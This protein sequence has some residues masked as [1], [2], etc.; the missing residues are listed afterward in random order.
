MGSFFLYGIAPSTYTFNYDVFGKVTKVLAGN[1]VLAI[2]T[3]LGNNGKLSKITY[4]NGF[5]EEYVYDTLENLSEIWYT[6]NSTRSLAYSY[7]YTSRGLIHKFEDHII[8]KAYTYKYDANDRLISYTEY[9]LDDPFMDF[10]DYNSR[11]S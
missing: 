4:A 7:E 2:Y 6:E 9:D 10:T 1:K 3:Y 5:V 8:G 11:Y